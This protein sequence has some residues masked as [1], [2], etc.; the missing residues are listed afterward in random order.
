MKADVC[1]NK[2]SLFLPLKKNVRKNNN[3]RTTR[4]N[5]YINMYGNHLWKVDF[6]HACY[7]Y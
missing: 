6:F 4:V 1:S 5:I 3:L 2:V 7:I